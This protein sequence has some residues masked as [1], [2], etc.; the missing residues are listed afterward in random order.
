MLARGYV[1]VATDYAGLGLPGVHAYLV[2][3][4]EARAVLDSV[5]AARNLKARTPPNALPCGGIRRGATPRCSPASWPPTYAP[6]LKLVGV[7]AAAPA[8]NLVELFKAQKGSIAGNSLTAMALLSWSRTY[9]LPLDSVLEDGC[10]GELRE[11]GAKAASSRCRRCSTCLK[12][13]KPL[14]KAFL[15]VDP[16]TVPAW[17][18]LMEQNSPGQA[19]IKAPVFIAQGDAAT[20]RSTPQITVASPSNAV[21]RRH[22]RRSS[23]VEER[24]AQLRRREERL[25]G[26][27]WIT[28][29]FKGRPAPSDCKRADRLGASS[30]A[31]C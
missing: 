26:R 12:L 27:Q 16:T 11:G 10:R 5:R 24:V 1:V 21:R 14:K 2:G 7:A 28:R 25:P 3:I 6:E 13:A 31:A 15:K 30:T 9:N 23:N 19:R 17:R 18:A 4:S 22:A 29:R 8:T 20:K